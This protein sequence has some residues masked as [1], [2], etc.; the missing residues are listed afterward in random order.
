[1]KNDQTLG[2]LKAAYEQANK[3]VEDGESRKAEVFERAA[4][5][6]RKA[7]NLPD[8]LQAKKR[9]R[10]KVLELFVLGQ[11]SQ[12]DLDQID[13]ELANLEH[14]EENITQTIDAAEKARRTIET[15]LAQLKGKRHTA[16][17]AIGEHLF[18]GLQIEIKKQIGEKLKQAAATYQIARGGAAWHFFLPILFD[19]QPTHEEIAKLR[20]E[21][22][23]TY[24]RSVSV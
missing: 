3:A 13:N 16:E 22:E 24:N 4:A 11:A 15:E 1:M 8:E 2:E 23:E 9:S 5:I 21:I 20:A 14:S 6:Q 18:S 10:A 19:G 12:E 17:Q 7:A